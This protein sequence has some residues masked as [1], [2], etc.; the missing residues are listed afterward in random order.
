[1]ATDPR[2]YLGGTRGAAHGYAASA[3]ASGN[4]VAV[5]AAPAAGAR[6]YVQGFAFHNAAVGALTIALAR[7]AGAGG[8]VQISAPFAVAAG[9]T[10]NVNFAVPLSAGAAATNVGIIA[11]GAGQVYA[12]VY[13]YH[14]A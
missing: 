7:G 12:N 4:G 2:Y 6:L 11:S 3:D 9:A 14:T 8:A 10:L 1:M 13:G 5:I